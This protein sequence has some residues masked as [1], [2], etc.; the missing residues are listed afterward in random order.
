M[1]GQKIMGSMKTDGSI[2]PQNPAPAASSPEPA[3]TSSGE[4]MSL[5][6][7]EVESP[8]D[9]ASEDADPGGSGWGEEEFW[10]EFKDLAA[11]PPPPRKE[12]MERTPPPLAVSTG[13]RKGSSSVSSAPKSMSMG[14]APTK[15]AVS[16]AGT[17]KAKAE[18]KKDA[19]L[20]GDDGDFWKEFDM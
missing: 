12:S 17:T 8:V 15:K 5:R 16:P 2:A 13:P 18:P 20:A 7:K 19:I 1:V 4:G 3:V 14:P 9:F 6:P 11:D 10:D